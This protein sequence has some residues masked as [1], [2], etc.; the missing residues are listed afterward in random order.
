MSSAARN[1]D[2]PFFFLSNGATSQPGACMIKSSTSK[3]SVAKEREY[4]RTFHALS[5]SSGIG[6]E[7]FGN[8]SVT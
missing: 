4:I 7:V 1:V 3:L 6:V 8:A 2:I 5:C